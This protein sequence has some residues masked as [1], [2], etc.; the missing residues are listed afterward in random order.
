MKPAQNRP[1]SSRNELK[2]REEGLSGRN[3]PDF[4]TV[5]PGFKSRAPDHVVG[6]GSHP[7]D[8]KT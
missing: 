7:D 5:R 3:S 2:T 8:F 6:E 4:G 1:V